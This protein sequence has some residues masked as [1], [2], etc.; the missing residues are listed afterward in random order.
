MTATDIAWIVARYLLCVFLIRSVFVYGYRI[1]LHP[2]HSLPGPFAARFSDCICGNYKAHA[3]PPDI[4]QSERLIKSRAYLVTQPLPD[5]YNLFNVLDKRLHR[6]KRR[7]IGQG[8]NERSMREFEPLMLGHIDTFVR[9]LVK[10][11]KDETAIVDMTNRCTYLG[12]DVIG[13]LGFGTALD[14]Q[15]SS[16]NRFMVAGLE[17]SNFRSNLYIQFP[18]L[19]KIG[20]EVLL[21]PFILTSQM[22]YYKMLR[23][24]IIARRSEEKH[25]RKDLYSFVAD[26]KDPETGEGMRLRDI[27]SEA[28]FFIPAGGDTTSTAISAAFF[29]LSRYPTCYERLAN[30]IRSTFDSASE[31]RNGPKLFNI[32]YLRAFIDETLRITPPICTTLWRQLPISAQDEAP[33]VI[34]GQVIPP[35][36]EVGVNIYTIHHN[37][38]YFPDPFTFKPERW[39]SESAV[40]ADEEKARKKLMHDAFTPFS[41]GSRG[42]AGKAMAYLEISLVLAKTLWYLDFHR[43]RNNIKADRVG[44]GF[45]GKTNGRDKKLEFQV[46]DQFSSVHHGPNLVFSLRGDLRKELYDTLKT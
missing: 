9:Q 15:T 26:I 22:K 30:E 17:T 3:I 24:L 39:L 34:D 7:I 45:E 42:C 10:S 8:V 20:M 37:E 2:L 4:Y 36:T 16:K 11:C 28:A 5:V 14:L 31:I 41:I 27:W 1:F 38:E 6:V 23:D 18:L 46:R 13:Q 19:K 12:L 44:E 25:A 33:L 32:A 35:G 29:Y 40:E 43:P 21:Y